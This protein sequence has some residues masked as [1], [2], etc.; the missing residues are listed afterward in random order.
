MNSTS[1]PFCTLHS[2]LCTN[3][4]FF[5]AWPHQIVRRHDDIN[6]VM[7]GRAG[8]VHIVEESDDISIKRIDGVQAAVRF[9]AML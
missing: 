4:W 7:L 2:A 1:D 5:V 6:S 8:M 3:G 9:A